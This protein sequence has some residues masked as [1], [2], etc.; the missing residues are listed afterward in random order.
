MNPHAQQSSP[1]ADEHKRPAAPPPG[2]D[3]MQESEKL[4][5]SGLQEQQAVA[6]VETIRD[7]QAGFATKEDLRI[8]LE[9]LGLVLRSEIGELRSEMHKEIGELR[10]EMHKEI[11]GLRGEIGELRGEM[12]K[13]F[14][15]MQWRFLIGMGVIVGIFEAIGMFAG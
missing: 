7:S 1:F 13:Q 10:S 6:I 15:T 2:F 9:Q 11:G 8:G 14:A 3:T 4:K 5:R 12:Q